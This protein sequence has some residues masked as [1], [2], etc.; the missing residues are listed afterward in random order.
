MFDSPFDWLAIAVAIVAFIVA[1]KALDEVASLRKRL[2]LMQTLAQV[3][4]ASPVVPPPLP[5][6]QEPERAAAPALPRIAAEPPPLAP[7]A[8]SVA[9]GPTL[10]AAGGAAPPTLPP[11]DRGF[12]ETLGTRW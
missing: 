12:E 3:S 6:R 2:D 10:E 5:P 11:P 7:D 9:P 1:R 8:P 4:A